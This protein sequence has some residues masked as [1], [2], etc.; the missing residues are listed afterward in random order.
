MDEIRLI[1][2][3]EDILADNKILADETR[4]TL[5]VAKTFLL[6]LMASPGAGK[7][8]LILKTIENLR[9]QIRIGVIEAD[10]DSVVDSEKIAAQ[11]IEAVQLRTGGFC[12]LD[13]SMVQKGIGAMDLSLLDLVVIENIGNLVCPAEVDTGALMNA[14]ILSVPEGDDKPL[15]YPL[16]FAASDVLVINKI[17]FLSISDFDL[18]AA[19]KRV[20]A[21]NP[22]IR[23][24]EVSSKTGQGIHAW[25][26]WLKGEVEAF[27][28]S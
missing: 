10:I 20:L 26:D 8:S 16:M 1:E 27:T 21:L 12:H 5:R 17:D 22:G 23:I 6:N 3:K 24:F 11:G 14:M 4:D 19:K 18:E 13:A 25:T 15:K 9:A 2:V 7:T 28:R